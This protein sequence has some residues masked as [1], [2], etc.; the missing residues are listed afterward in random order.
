MMINVIISMIRM[1]RMIGMIRMVRNKED[2]GCDDDD[3]DCY[4]NFSLGYLPC[5]IILS[6][7]GPCITI[8]LLRLDITLSYVDVS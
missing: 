6:L 7:N 8:I 2:I 3:C 5:L 1:I 4:D